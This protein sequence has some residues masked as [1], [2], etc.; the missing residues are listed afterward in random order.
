M[1]WIYFRAGK[2]L[3]PEVL[4]KYSDERYLK[5]HDILINSTGLG[6]VEGYVYLKQIQNILL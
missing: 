5:K 6:T 2:Y 1:E 4:E 3:A